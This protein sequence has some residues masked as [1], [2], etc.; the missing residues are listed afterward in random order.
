MLLRHKSAA[1]PTTS[2][3]RG[4]TPF[5]VDDKAVC[6]T[7]HMTLSRWIWRSEGVEPLLHAS[8][9]MLSFVESAKV[10]RALT[11]PSRNAPTTA[12]RTQSAQTYF[13]GRARSHP[14]RGACSQRIRNAS[15]AL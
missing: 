7:A 10:S 8:V 15:S 3:P 9:T 14:H 13:F 4:H 2:G 5:Q 1:Q 11:N 6:R 12:P